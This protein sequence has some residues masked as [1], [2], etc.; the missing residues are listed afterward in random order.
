[1]KNIFEMK[2]IL[3]LILIFSLTNCNILKNNTLD[4]SLKSI[5][6]NE[7][8]AIGKSLTLNGK[9]MGYSGVDCIFFENFNAYP[10]ETRSDW[11]FKQQEN[12]IYVTGGFPGGLN[13]AEFDDR[14]KEIILKAKVKKNDENKL[15]LE[16]IDAHLKNF[17]E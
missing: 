15:Y 9:F 7:S 1:M 17:I 5:S 10:P 14:G 2:K 12:C 3:Y 16:F 11:I 8:T 6:V 13:P 4:N